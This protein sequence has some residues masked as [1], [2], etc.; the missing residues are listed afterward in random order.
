M[1]SLIFKDKNKLLPTYIP[2]SLPHRGKQLNQLKL[3][4]FDSLEK[5]SEKFLKIAQLIGVTGSGKT[6]TAILFT[7]EF[8]KE[9]LKKKL[10]IKSVY[11]NLRLLGTS[12]VVLYRTMVL[13]AAPEIFSQNLSALEM[14]NELINYLKK[15]KTYL[16]AVFDE[17]DYFVNYSREKLV[18]ELTRLSELSPGEP[19]NFLGEIF[20]ARS[21]KFHEKLEPAELSTLGRNYIRFQSYNH[22]QLKDILLLRVNESFKPGVVSEDL[23]EFISDLCSKPPINGDARAALDLLLYAGTLAEVQGF[24]KIMPE[25]VRSVFKE[26]SYLITTDEILNLPFQEK[27][28][29]LS[30]AR[31][32]Q[33]KEEPYVPYNKIKEV[34]KVVCEELKQRKRKEIDEQLQNLADKGL[35]EIKGLTK[36]G[37]SGVETAELNAF[38]NGLIMKINKVMETVI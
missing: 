18:Y 15:K 32:L 36:I 22:K 27:V 23:V 34:Y 12:K 38:L 30:V 29:L 13:K 16:I 6:C 11:L 31:A 10:R 37:V 17:I 14:L 4:F 8:E 7:K 35:I 5:P 24:R 2:N 25:H 19:L 20:I 26:K 3:L 28:V 9:A 21:K 33:R 1:R